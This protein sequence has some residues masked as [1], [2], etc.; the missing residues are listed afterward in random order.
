M[1]LPQAGSARFS[2]SDEQHVYVHV[3]GSNLPSTWIERWLARSPSVSSI[4]LLHDV[5]PLTHPEYVR[6]KVPGR[7]A[8]VRTPRGEGG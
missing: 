8:Q 7:H 1:L 6:A 4:F 3:S 5:I 2:H